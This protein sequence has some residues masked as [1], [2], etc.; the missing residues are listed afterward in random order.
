M[1]V[2]PKRKKTFSSPKARRR[3]DRFHTDVR[4]SIAL[5]DQKSFVIIALFVGIQVF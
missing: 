1:T 2:L 4:K 3:T 5:S